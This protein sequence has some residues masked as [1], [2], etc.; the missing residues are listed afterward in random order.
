[1]RAWGPSERGRP[2]RIYDLRRLHVHTKAIGGGVALIAAET[3]DPT[4]AINIRHYSPGYRLI[5]LR[6]TIGARK[7]A[8]ALPV[9]VRVVD[10]P[11]A[12]PPG[13]LIRYSGKVAIV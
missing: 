4:S 3:L 1:V 11:R 8:A 5:E 7:P 6:A 12:M 2:V 10:M 9:R 13:D